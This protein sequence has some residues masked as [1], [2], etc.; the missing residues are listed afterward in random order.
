[1]S[2]EAQCLGVRFTE[3][4]SF[5]PYNLEAF[6]K[7]VVLGMIKMARLPPKLGQTGRKGRAKSTEKPVLYRELPL[8]LTGIA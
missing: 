2:V 4:R 1:L 3:I 5:K 7:E 6:H 8:S